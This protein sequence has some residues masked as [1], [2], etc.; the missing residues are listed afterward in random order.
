MRKQELIQSTVLFTRLTGHCPLFDGFL[1][2]TIHSGLTFQS[3]WDTEL[4]GIDEVVFRMS[5]SMI[6]ILV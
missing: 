6:T 3:D 5:L 2:Q 4:T 1:S